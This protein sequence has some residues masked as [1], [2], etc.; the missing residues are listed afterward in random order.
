M[1]ILTCQDTPDNVAIINAL[2]IYNLLKME[3]MWNRIYQNI[4][5]H[6]SVA[7]L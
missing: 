7:E 2:Y 5:G 3:I 4:V 6:K 1:D